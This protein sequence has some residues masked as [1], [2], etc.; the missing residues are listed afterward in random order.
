MNRLVVDLLAIDG[1]VTSGYQEYILYLLGY[2][3][4]NRNG[5][6]YDRVLLLCRDSASG[7]FS[8]FR[9]KFEVKSYSCWSIVKRFWL[10]SMILFRWH[11]NREDLLLSPGNYSGWFKLCPEILAIHDLLYKRREWMPRILVRMQRGLFIS[12][13]IH[14]AEKVV[15][16]SHATRADIERF[17]PTA[18]GKVL[19]I[20][21]PMNFDRFDG[22]DGACLEWE[23]FLAVSA[24]YIHKNQITI[25]RAFQHYI[26]GGG[27]RHLVMIGEKM[28]KSEAVEY[29]S[30]LPSSVKDMI[31]WKENISNAELGL[32]YRRASC[33]ISASLFEGMG[34]PVVEAMSLGA[35]VLL[36]D[37][38]VHREM[39]LGLGEYFD[40]YDYKDLASRMKGIDPRRR[41]YG[42][43]IR[44]AFSEQNTSAKY[45]ALINSFAKS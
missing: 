31:V 18:N 13:S 19:V 43:K 23:Y 3:Y 9:D 42:P 44:E 17:Y 14:K 41:D 36:S 38:P 4:R 40:P 12:R 35:P 7:L 29:Y 1:R 32:L 30:K 8:G 11:L 39:S 20:N 45:M 27:E 28:R 10:E 34:M 22:A 6:L 16:I 2:L 15:A 5:L 25:L 33:F 26:R 37:I 24:N 21:N